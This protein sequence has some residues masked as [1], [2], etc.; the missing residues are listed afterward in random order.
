MYFCIVLVLQY[1]NYYQHLIGNNNFFSVFILLLLQRIIYLRS[2]SKNYCCNIFLAREKWKFIKPNG[3][4]CLELKH[5]IFFFFSLRQK[6]TEL[7]GWFCIENDISKINTD[8]HNL[9]RKFWIREIL[10]FFKIV[11]NFF[12]EIGCNSHGHRTAKMI[13]LRTQLPKSCAQSFWKNEKLEAKKSIWA[14]I[15]KTK[16]KLELKTL[17]TVCYAKT[18]Q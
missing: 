14:I 18:L 8:N 16:K 12:F 13:F 9:F 5:I 2:T 10:D 1:K 3:E 15:R 6:F 11:F 4:F 7:L 17:H